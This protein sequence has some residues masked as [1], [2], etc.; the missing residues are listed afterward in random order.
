MNFSDGFWKERPIGERAVLAANVR[1]S[2]PIDCS[3]DT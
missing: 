1:L 2:E 3:E